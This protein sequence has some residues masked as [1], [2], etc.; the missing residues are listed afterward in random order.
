MGNK[1]K[2]LYN[3]FCKND[4][5]TNIYWISVIL[6]V[7]IILCYVMDYI[8]ASFTGIK[9]TRE[10]NMIRLLGIPCP[11]CGGTRALISLF[12]GDIMKALYYNAF[13]VFSFVGY[14]VFFVSQSI[15]ML[16]KGKVKGMEF[17]GIYCVVLLIILFVQYALRFIIPGYML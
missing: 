8:V 15:R 6:I 5:E 9:V 1:I 2:T 7:P 10:C 16:T 14:A 13:A 4:L 12:K 3:R 17:R 11:G